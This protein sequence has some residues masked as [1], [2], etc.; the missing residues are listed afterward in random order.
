V[1][2]RVR[3]RVLVRFR[4]LPPAPVEEGME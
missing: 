1:L 4:A 2:V 3:V